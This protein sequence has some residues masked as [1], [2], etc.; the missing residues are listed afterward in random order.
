MIA[1]RHRYTGFL[2]GMIGAIAMCMGVAIA[3]PPDYSVIQNYQFDEAFKVDMSAA[4]QPLDISEFDDDLP[5]KV[6][7]AS[8]ITF[9]RCQDYGGGCQ[10]Y[11]VLH[12]LDMQKDWEHPYTPDL[13]WRYVL[14]TFQ[15]RVEQGVQAGDINHVDDIPPLLSWVFEQGVAPEALCRSELDLLTAVPRPT[16]HVLHDPKYPGAIMDY[17]PGPDG[18]ATSVAQL[19][20]ATVSEPITPDVKTLRTLLHHYGPIWSSG[21]WWWNGGH[22]MVFVGYDDNK[23]E[24]T[25]LN[26]QGDWWGNQDG[27]GTC[28]YDDLTSWVES[29]RVVHN[30]P[31]PEPRPEHHAYTA[32]IRIDGVW[33]GT[34]TVS[35]GVQGR[36]LLEVWRTHGR[37]SR[38]PYEYSDTP[39]N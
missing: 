10:C 34:H 25:F 13:S 17:N 16:T 4:V 29:L 33:R 35:V 23:R 2:V 8:W 32:R 22:A 37:S 27:F 14:N 26:S 7:Y 28:P 24:F 6:N 38:R 11:S 18:T 39:A 9:E 1:G 19:Y 21:G 3:A 36:E 30:T 5:A 20:K 31:T 15:D 12:I